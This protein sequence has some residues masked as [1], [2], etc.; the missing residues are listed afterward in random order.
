MSPELA[1]DGPQLGLKIRLAGL[2]LWARHRPRDP[3]ISISIRHQ[4]PTSHPPGPPHT[5][6]TPEGH[7]ADSTVCDGAHQESR[8]LASN[9]SRSE[10]DHVTIHCFMGH[11][12]PK[13]RVI[14]KGAFFILYAICQLR[15]PRPFPVIVSCCMAGEFLRYICGEQVASKCNI[16]R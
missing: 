3:G 9:R 13:P 5:V 10:A 16:L 14:S 6:I 7:I 4:P 11:P 2:G 15:N 1:R 8:F 12:I